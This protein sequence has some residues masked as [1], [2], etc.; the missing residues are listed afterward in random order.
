MALAGV[1]VLA[2]LFA[3]GRAAA[4][5]QAADDAIRP[6]H[7]ALRHERDAQAGAGPARDLAERLVRLGALDQAGRALLHTID[8]S[9]LPEGERVPASEAMWR[10]IGAQDS[11]DQAALV[12]LLPPQ[13]WFTSDRVG[14]DAASAAWSV[15]QHATGNLGLM[16]S[17]L[18]RMTPAVAAGQVAADD[19]AKLLDRVAMLKG[20]PQTYGTQFKCVDHA[21]RRYAMLD[22]EHVE[23]RR[24]AL[25]MTETAAAE[26]AVIAAYPPCWFGRQRTATRARGRPSGR[27][28]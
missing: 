20:E 12:A 13:G 19:Y 10:E 18:E 1:V 14:A 8:L 7:E 15:V 6:V 5:S 11:E 2:G 27:R 16:Q 4:L 3:A 17:V 23:E 28:S 25:G 9:R 26:A 21:W 24:R 22:P